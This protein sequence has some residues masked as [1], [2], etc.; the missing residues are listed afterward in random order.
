MLPWRRCPDREVRFDVLL[1]V[2]LPIASTAVSIVLKCYLSFDFKIWARP[3]SV[4]ECF[5][6]SRP[7]I[8]S[9]VVGREGSAAEM[10]CPALLPTLQSEP[11]LRSKIG[12]SR[13]QPYCEGYCQGYCEGYQVH[14]K[15]GGKAECNLG[16]K[17]H[18]R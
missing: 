4:F 8:P 6:P 15:L 7:L 9:S 16:G 10:V 12:G 3:C 1:L 13:Y 14:N 18:Q 17:V 5:F 2:F 11:E